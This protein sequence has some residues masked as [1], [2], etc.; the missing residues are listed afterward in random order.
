MDEGSYLWNNVEL[1]CCNSSIKFKNNCIISQLIN[2][3]FS[4]RPLKKEIEDV[5]VVWS[6][7]CSMWSI[8]CP[9]MVHCFKVSKGA[10]I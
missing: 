5:L 10:S 7:P 3:V 6:C 9:S 2:S 1:F 4:L 8:I